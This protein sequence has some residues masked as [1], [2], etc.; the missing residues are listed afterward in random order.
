VGLKPSAS[1]LWS[2]RRKETESAPELP[3]EERLPSTQ[4]V[5]ERGL[6]KPGAA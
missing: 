5:S 2:G 4:P 6:R 3:V 1:G